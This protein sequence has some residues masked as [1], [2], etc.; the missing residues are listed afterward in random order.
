MMKWLVSLVVIAITVQAFASGLVWRERGNGGAYDGVPFFLFDGPFFHLDPE[1][2]CPAGSRGPQQPGYREQLRMSHFIP[3]GCKKGECR[4]V[5]YA[6]ENACTGEIVYVEN[7]ELWKQSMEYAVG[8]SVI[9]FKLLWF[10]GKLWN[11]REYIPD[12]DSP[13]SYKGVY[14][15]GVDPR[16]SRDSYEV[17]VE[18]AAA[19]ANARNAAGWTATVYYR[20]FYVAPGD[21]H[22]RE[23]QLKSIEELPVARLQ[24]NGNLVCTNE[25]LRLEVSAQQELGRYWEGS[26]VLKLE[27]GAT[28]VP[29]TCYVDSTH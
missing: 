22:D 7:P 18:R 17:L 12:P 8:N 11:K 6:R 19:E 21:E 29:L 10:D 27:G 23:F 16:D 14:C 26:L 5:V 2:T 4:G 24:S 1:F 3:N 9:D 15:T 25:N 28:T 13:D 20:D